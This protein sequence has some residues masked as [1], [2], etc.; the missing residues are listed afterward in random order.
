MYITKDL[1]YESGHLQPAS[2]EGDWGEY[3]N[4]F[5]GGVDIL[6]IGRWKMDTYISG[7]DFRVVFDVGGMHHTLKSELVYVPEPDGST[8]VK[9]HCYFDDKDVYSSFLPLMKKKENLLH[10][11]SSDLCIV[12]Y[13]NHILST[14]YQVMRLGLF[15]ILFSSDGTLDPQAIVIGSH[16]NMG[17]Y[18]Y[19]IHQVLWTR[20]SEIARYSLLYHN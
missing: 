2:R 19:L 10:S 9:C 4:L 17:R 16:S 18:D 14:K 6:D 20:D 13:C 8:L 5:G 12:E 15:L 3:L 1:V 7:S 11:F